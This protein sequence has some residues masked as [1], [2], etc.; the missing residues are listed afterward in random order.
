MRTENAG[1]ALHIEA[2]PAP[3]LRI[4][5]GRPGEPPW[6]LHGEPST[7]L[8]SFHSW[9]VGAGGAVTYKRVGE[10]WVGTEDGHFLVELLTRDLLHNEPAHGGL[11]G[12]PMF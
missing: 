6:E 9:K 5:T 1:F 3:L 11:K 10:H 8:L 4:T 7:G 12:F 2:D